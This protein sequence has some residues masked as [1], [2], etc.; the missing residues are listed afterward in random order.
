MTHGP[1]PQRLA[2]ASLC[3]LSLPHLLRLHLILLPNHLL[4]HQLFHRGNGRV[5]PPSSKPP[6]RAST[7]IHTPHTYATPPMGG[8]QAHGVGTLHKATKAR[9]PLPTSTSDPENTTQYPCPRVCRTTTKLYKTPSTPHHSRCLPGR[10]YTTWERP[11]PTAL[12][13][14]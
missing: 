2:Q 13:T 1:T 8:W 3:S 9:P 14:W 4:T 10:K 5:A 12:P 7:P 6:Q 11:P